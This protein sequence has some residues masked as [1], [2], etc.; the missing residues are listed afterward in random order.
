MV[1][2]VGLT[3]LLVVTW[4]MFRGNRSIVSIVSSFFVFFLVLSYIIVSTRIDWKAL[5]QKNWLDNLL[6][7]W[8]IGQFPIDG[9][10]TTTLATPFSVT[11]IKFKHF[12]WRQGA[13]PA[14]EEIVSKSWSLMSSL[15]VIKRIRCSGVVFWWPLASMTIVYHIVFSYTQAQI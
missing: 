12:T 14:A 1:A 7:N 3:G 5:H 4:L 11:F 15:I 8:P 6:S 13:Y 2:T 9:K 10:P